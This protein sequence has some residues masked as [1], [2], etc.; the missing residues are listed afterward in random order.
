MAVIDLR[1]VAPPKVDDDSSTSVEDY[2]TA[3]PAATPA[4]AANDLVRAVNDLG[5]NH[6][7]AR[8]RHQPDFPVR[9]RIY[10]GGG[11]VL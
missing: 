1:D 2:S 11:M 3:E 4:E 10:E 8:V 7:V 5:L 6:E 9:G